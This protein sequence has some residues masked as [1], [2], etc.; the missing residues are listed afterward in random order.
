MRE[1]RLDRRDE[2]AER[3]E[4]R[5]RPPRRTS[6]GRAG[7]WPTCGQVG[8]GLDAQRPQLVGGADAAS[9]GGS[10]GCRTRP[11]PARPRSASMRSPSASTTARARAVDDLEAVD[12]DVGPQREVRPAAGGAARWVTAALWRTPSTWFSGI[13]PAP[14]APRRVVVVD[15]R[16]AAARRSRRGT[17]GGRAASASGRSGAR[18]AGRRCRARSP[19]AGRPRGA[20][21]GEHVVPRPRRVAGGDPAV[22]V[23]RRRAHDRRAVDRRRSA[24]DL[25]PQDGHRLG[26]SLPR[27]A[28]PSGATPAPAR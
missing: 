26:R 21:G 1:H 25:A 9:A 12:G 11:R 2:L 22:E 18:A 10:P 13:G 23:A 7:C 17:P 28:A 19:G 20:E 15:Q 14:I 24:D 5:P 27:C 3:V 6:G 16:V 8:D 4:R